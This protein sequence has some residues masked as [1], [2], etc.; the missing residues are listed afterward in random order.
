MM[1]TSVHAFATIPRTRAT[2][3][4]YYLGRP[5]YEETNPYA[6]KLPEDFLGKPMIE[7]TVEDALMLAL[8]ADKPDPSLDKIIW[9]KTVFD[10]AVEAGAWEH[11]LGQGTPRYTASLDAAIRLYPAC[12][13]MISTDPLD[14]VCDALRIRLL[15]A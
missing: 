11:L 15:S 3:T 9:Y 10:P 12:P 7:M 5:V 1:T 4:R 2:I 6:D 13:P 8:A 14:V